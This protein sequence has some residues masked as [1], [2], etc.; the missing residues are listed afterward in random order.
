M[1][2]AEAFAVRNPVRYS[3]IDGFASGMGYTFVLLMVSVV[4]ELLAFGTLLN[5][6]IMPVTFPTWAVMALAPGGFFVLG[7]FIWLIREWIHYYETV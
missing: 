5:I 4:R 6:Q 3:L 7:L 2:R 1:G